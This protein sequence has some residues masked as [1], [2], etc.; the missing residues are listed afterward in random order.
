ML[1]LQT[2]KVSIPTSLKLVMADG[3]LFLYSDST[4][5]S[6]TQIIMKIY[7]SLLTNKIRKSYSASNIFSKTDF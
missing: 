6:R 4:Y 7:E 3:F 1:F 5:Y 2:E